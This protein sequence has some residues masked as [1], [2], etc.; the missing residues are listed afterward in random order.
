MRTW[1]LLAAVVAAGCGGTNNNNDGGAG[2]G[3]VQFAASGEVLALGGYDFPPAHR[4]RPRLRRRLGRPLHAVRRRVR[5]DRRCRRIP[6]RSPS[7]QSQTGKLVAEVDGPWAIDLH[8][9]GLAPGKGGGDEQA[10]PIAV[11]T[12]QNKNGGAAFATDGTRYAFGFDSS[13]ATRVGEDN[14]QPRRRRVADYADD[15]AERVRR[16]L[17]RHRDVQGQ[18]GRA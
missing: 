15:D 13:P 4:R 2:G 12:N 9:G 5:Q 16:A 17:R 7:D 8:K 3:A 18:Q 10:V 6:T 14:V 11:L 1:W